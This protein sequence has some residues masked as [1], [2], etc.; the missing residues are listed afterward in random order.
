MPVVSAN[1]TSGVGGNSPAVDDN[2]EN[3]KSDNGSHLD[4]AKNELDLT[5]AADT[6]D[7]DN[8]DA[9]QED[10]DP[11]TD[12]D[13]RSASVLWVGPESDGDTGS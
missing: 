3:D 10:C 8:N 11:D 7:V 9:E 2:A 4:Q 5:V 12:V 13:G 6:E 1:V